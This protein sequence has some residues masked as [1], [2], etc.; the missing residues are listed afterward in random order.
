MRSSYSR[1]L[2]SELRIHGWSKTFIANR[3][4]PRS[5]RLTRIH[6]L[7]DMTA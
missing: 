4:D 7:L 2:L 1:D 3:Y 5:L 6:Q